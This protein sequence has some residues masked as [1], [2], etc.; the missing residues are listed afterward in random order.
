MGRYAGVIAA[1][2]P[3]GPYNQPLPLTPARASASTNA[4]ASGATDDE[5]YSSNM[6]LWTVG[7]AHHLGACLRPHAAHAEHGEVPGRGVYHLV[8]GR[9]RHRSAAAQLST[10]GSRL[11]LA[12]LLWHAWDSRFCG[13][14]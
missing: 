3:F 1:A 6:A 12:N 4:S 7:S 5:G 13:P 8:R 9:F 11:F 2:L 14:H 10:V